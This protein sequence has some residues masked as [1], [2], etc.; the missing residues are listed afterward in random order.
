MTLLQVLTPAYRNRVKDRAEALMETYEG[1]TRSEKL[2]VR[3][4]QVITTASYACVYSCIIIIPWEL[5]FF[6]L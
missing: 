5:L 2:Q 4:A 3:E 6:N 1:V